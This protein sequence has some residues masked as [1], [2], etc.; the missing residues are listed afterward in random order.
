M[1]VLSRKA[2][3]TI[4]FPSL[5]ISVQVLRCSQNNVRIG[6]DAPREIAVLRGEIEDQE[7]RAGATRV[8][9]NRLAKSVLPNLRQTVHEAAATL[10]QLHAL[11]D[12]PSNPKCEAAIFKLFEDLRK[13]D[14]QVTELSK[15]ESQRSRAIRA[16]L[17][18]DDD[19]ELQLLSRYLEAKGIDV[20][21]AKNGQIALKQ[22]AHCEPDI[23]LLNMSMPKFDGR[24]TI[25]KIRGDHQLEKLKVF[26]I[27]GTDEADSDVEVGPHGVNGWFRKPLNPADLILEITNSCTHN[28]PVL[29]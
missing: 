18:D 26:A 13:L 27:S 25:D 8:A 21:T 24:W 6:I 7:V 9:A 20:T 14:S 1:L 4:L 15:P 28:Q 3:E 16:L 2:N 22:M 5:G 23:V 29:N 10:N 19:I 11:A 17:V 12:A